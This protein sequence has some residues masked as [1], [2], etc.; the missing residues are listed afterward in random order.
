M[1]E[2]IRER[3]INR[4]HEVG[5]DVHARECNGVGPNEAWSFVWSTP[6]IQFE[7]ESDWNYLRRLFVHRAVGL[8]P[9][10]VAGNVKVAD[11]DCGINGAAVSILPSFTPE[12][13]VLSSRSADTLLGLKQRTGKARI[14]EHGEPEQIE[15]HPR[16]DAFLNG[17]RLR[18]L[19]TE[20]YDWVARVAPNLGASTLT[21]R[22]VEPADA[23]EFGMIL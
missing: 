12:R 21:L 18:Y 10:R 6:Q 3:N 9:N 22:E 17:V 19:R 14:P 23:R 20:I 15:T 1:L 11:L 2:L 4:I 16:S 5:D 7:V 13:Q 8:S